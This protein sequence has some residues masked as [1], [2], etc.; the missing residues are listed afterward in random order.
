[1]FKSQHLSKRANKP[2]P[3]NASSKSSTPIRTFS[4]NPVPKSMNFNTSQGG[5]FYCSEEYSK[6]SPTCN[7]IRMSYDPCPAEGFK[8][9]LALGIEELSWQ[10]V[11]EQMQV[12]M[13]RTGL[14]HSIQIK[15]SLGILITKSEFS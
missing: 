15:H 11:I 9:W 12:L 10:V 1:M 6:Q 13:N 3:E 7:D 2:I 14:S 4:M 8:G 5:V